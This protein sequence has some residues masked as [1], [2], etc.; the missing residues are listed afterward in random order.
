MKKFFVAAAAVS[1]LLGAT[2]ISQAQTVHHV[3][4]VHHTVHHVVVKHVVRHVAPVRHVVR[5]TTPVR[6]VV[7]AHHVS[8]TS[9]TAKKQ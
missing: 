7:P 9:L 8:H 2:N 5:H 6:H 3:V 1:F 4:P